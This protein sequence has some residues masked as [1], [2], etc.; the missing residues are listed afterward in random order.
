MTFTLEL[1]M[2]WFIPVLLFAIGLYKIAKCK[3]Y[4]IDEKSSLVW[5]LT[6]TITILVIA[7]LGIISN[8]YSEKVHK[9]A[10]KY[11]D[12]VTAWEVF[13]FETVPYKTLKERYSTK[14]EDSRRA[15]EQEI[16]EEKKY[17]G[18]Q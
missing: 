6:C 9:H 4:A 2:L 14:R 15:I 11:R 1:W 5:L 10:G 13:T 3:T 7:P 17:R 16:E 12:Y 18:E 8:K